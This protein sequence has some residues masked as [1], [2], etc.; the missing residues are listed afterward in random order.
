M[1]RENS[2]A[3]CNVL[4]SSADLVAHQSSQSNAKAKFIEPQI[5]RDGKR[6]D[7]VINNFRALRDTAEYSPYWL[8]LYRGTQQFIYH[9]SHSKTYILNEQ[10]HP[11][12]RCT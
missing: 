10:M 3:A 1:R 11:K 9:R 8:A 12:E 7:A 4:P 6:S 2:T 5:C